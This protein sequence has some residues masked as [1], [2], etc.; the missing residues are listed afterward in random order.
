[1]DNATGQSHL[2]RLG[3]LKTSIFIAVIFTLGGSAACQIP[4]IS[5]GSDASYQATKAA[6]DV[7]ATLLAQQATNQAQAVNLGAEATRMAQ[8]V[9]A[10]VLAQQ[11]TDMAALP[12]PVAAQPTPQEA[13]AASPTTEAPTS[14]PTSVPPP[15]Q[16]PPPPLEENVDAQ[17]KAARILLYEDMSG[18]GEL[19]LVKEALDM[20]GYSYTDDGS[21][22]G[23][24]KDHLLSG[25]D[26]DLVIYSSETRKR[27]TGEYFVYLFDQ[28]KK[29][30]A[31][32]IEIWNLDEFE[33]GKIAPLLA[34]CGVELHKDWFIPI[35]SPPVLSVWWL[36]PEHPVFHEPNEGMTLRNYT[37]FW[38]DDPDKGDLLKLTAGGDATMLA[39]IKAEEKSSYGTLATCFQGRVII[40]THSTHEYRREDITQMW[41]NMIYYVLKNHFLTA[42]KSGY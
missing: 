26:W 22:Q 16:E 10:T 27:A 31:V 5:T 32:I 36:V 17:I 35:T 8:E 24:F 2:A 7:Q 42:P 13:V 33:F 25:E 40:Q 9:Q 29:G 20:A 30:A 38:W 23:W 12:T 15:T 39:G 37:N 4:L 19:R 11:A 21:A 28:I 1:M 6:L 34:S 3:I 14:A 18:R 41:E